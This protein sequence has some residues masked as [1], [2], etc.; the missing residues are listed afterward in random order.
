MLR[1]V[2]EQELAAHH[3]RNFR[4]AERGFI[5]DSP[6]VNDAKFYLVTGKDEATATLQG[7]PLNMVNVLALLAGS[8]PESVSLKREQILNTY[9]TSVTEAMCRERAGIGS[10]CIDCKA[11]VRH[12]YPLYSIAKDYHVGTDG[13]CRHFKCPDPETT[14][15]D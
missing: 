11:R 14:C 3:D 7:I 4:Y 6:N 5:V 9:A 1:K 2:S 12:A 10:F 13:F 15:G 8:V